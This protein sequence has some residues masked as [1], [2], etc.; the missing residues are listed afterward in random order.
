MA[1][2]RAANRQISSNGLR[3]IQSI[4]EHSAHSRRAGVAADVR[5]AAFSVAV[6]CEKASRLFIGAAGRPLV[7][8]DLR[9]YVAEDFMTMR[10]ASA[11]VVA[12]LVGVSPFIANAE[13]SCHECTSGL[14]G[15]CVKE[16]A[17]RVPA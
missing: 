13:T 2:V 5:N 12:A 11:V 3:G 7:G 17:R 9:F 15:A 10:L 6:L 4:I 16:A 14:A 8:C 1:K